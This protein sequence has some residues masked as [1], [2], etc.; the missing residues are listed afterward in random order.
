[1]S[2]IIP[3]SSHPALIVIA[4]ISVLLAVL[5]LWHAG[6][7]KAAVG[8]IEIQSLLFVYGL[9]TALS[10][11]TMSSLLEQGS[12]SLAVLSSIHIAVI[13]VLFWILLGNAII[14]T[15]FVE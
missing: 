14:A 6:R 12:K 5:L 11:V 2:L 4:S 8:R 15:Q 10:V 3:R 1:M 7:R 13:V 9:H